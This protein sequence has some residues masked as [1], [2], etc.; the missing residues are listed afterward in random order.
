M[1]FSHVYSVCAPVYSF[2]L[3]NTP[4]DSYAYV[5]QCYTGFVGWCGFSFILAFSKYFLVFKT[6]YRAIINDL[7]QKWRLIGKLV[8]CGGSRVAIVDFIVCV[9]A[10]ILYENNAALPLY[11]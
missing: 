10:A 2:R 5:Q 3:H 6:G 8:L 7:R 4:A 11:L 1:L 9:C